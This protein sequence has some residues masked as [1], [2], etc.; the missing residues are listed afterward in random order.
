M[1]RVSA[2]HGVLIILAVWGVI[3]FLATT[4]AFALPLPPEWLKAWTGLIISVVV[5]AVGARVLWVAPQQF[6]AYIDKLK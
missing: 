5:A 2:A 4:G 1:P 3:A 6:Q